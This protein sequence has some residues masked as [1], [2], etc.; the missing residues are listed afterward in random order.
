MQPFTVSQGKKFLRSMENTVW[1][2]IASGAKNPYVQASKDFCEYV[3][4]TEMTR[5]PECIRVLHEA[6]RLIYGETNFALSED[7]ITIQFKK[8]CDAK[9]F[10]YRKIFPFVPSIGRGLGQKQPKPLTKSAHAAIVKIQAAISKLS[11][12][13]K[14]QVA[15][16]VMP[17]LRRSTKKTTGG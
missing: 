8:G 1:K 9:T 14:Q 12:K 5:D 17:L 3:R 13:E 16:H 11:P 4:T 7:G 15:K 10:F 2:G 6:L